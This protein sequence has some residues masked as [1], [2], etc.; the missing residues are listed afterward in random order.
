MVWLEAERVAS[1]VDRGDCGWL[2]RWD[3]ATSYFDTALAVRCAVGSAGGAHTGVP[4]LWSASSI[5]L[6]GVPVSRLQR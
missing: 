4:R 6:A 3:L 5:V 2:L 1:A